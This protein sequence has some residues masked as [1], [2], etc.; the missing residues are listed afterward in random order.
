MTTN[1]DWH[2]IIYLME[3]CAGGSHLRQGIWQRAVDEFWAKLDQEERDNIYWIA[4]RD[5]TER[6]F[7]ELFGEQH[8][9]FGYDDFAEFLAR[10][11]PSNQ[12]RVTMDGEVN[13]KHTHEVAD[14]FL[15]ARSDDAKDT[16]AC[17]HTGFNRFCAPEFIVQTEHKPY[18]RCGCN[19]CP[20][21]GNCARWFEVRGI[22][23]SSISYY[24][25][26]NAGDRIKCDNYINSNTLSGI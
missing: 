23:P 16:G 7:H 18:K 24:Q 26:Y 25:Y 20:L 1:L 10:F 9:S 5:I 22:P 13:G 17:Y 21:H 8:T 14:A 15:W 19:N 12:Y 4:K 2:D 11:N 6:F 3:G